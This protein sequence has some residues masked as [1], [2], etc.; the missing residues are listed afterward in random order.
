[1]N[2]NAKRGITRRKLLTSA[3]GAGVLGM[4]NPLNLLAASD[5]SISVA[6]LNRFAQSL[7][8]TL[9]DPSAAAYESARRTFSFNQKFSRHPSLIVKCS[10]EADVARALGFAQESDLPVA[11]RSGG[12]DVLAEST[13]DNGLLI[14]LQGLSKIN[15]ANSIVG[16]G[17]GVLAGQLDYSLGE[18]GRALSLTC[19]PGVGVGGLTLG[20]GLGWFIGSQG[21]ACDR[22]KSARIVTVSGQVLTASND[23][24]QDL[25]WAI[26]GGGGNF[27]IVTELE[28]ST[29]QKPD[30]IAGVI[31]YDA[32]LLKEFLNFYRDFMV[33]APDELTVEI[34][35]N[36][37]ERPVIAAMVFYSGNDRDA[38]KILA[39]L[40]SFGPPLVDDLKKQDYGRVGLMTPNVSQFFTPVNLDIRGEEKEPGMYWQ[41]KSVSSLTENAISNIVES[42]NVAPKSWAFGLGH[43]MRGAVTRVDAG[44][45]PLNRPL[46]STTVHFDIGWSHK[47]QAMDR[48]KWVD[49]SIEALSSSAS[50]FD[51]INYMSSNDPDRVKAAYG[52]NFERLVTI[53]QRYDPE[54]ILS[55]NRNISPAQI[56]NQNSI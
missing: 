13:V 1:M 29:F 32:K 14:D 38:E 33:S 36:G 15:I 45:T 34:T 16:V 5:N 37:G 44:S 25:F 28:F 56:S 41:G 12:H 7:D 53:K 47:S 22:L 26:R 6:R 23:E 17:P 52:E 50:E 35:V 30:L 18:A 49:D 3:L 4:A 51:Y 9:I 21:A 19:N 20:G 27:G 42:V 46:H 10:S 43:V 2:L 48:M 8:G 31:V 39:P 54:N 11:V 55:H 24:N 40:R